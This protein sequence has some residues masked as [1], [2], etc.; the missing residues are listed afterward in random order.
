[1]TT[2]KVPPAS[3]TI[4][5]TFDS[6]IYIIS[7]KTP[8]QVRSAIDAGGDMIRMPNGAYIHKKSISTIQDFHDYNFQAEQKAFHKKG[9]YISRGEWIDHHGVPLG[10]NAHLERISGNLKALPLSGGFEKIDQVKTLPP[11]E[12]K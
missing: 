12:Q 5:R 11:H 4:I 2:Q 10:L 1:M 9:N 8:D 3:S 6:D 7:N